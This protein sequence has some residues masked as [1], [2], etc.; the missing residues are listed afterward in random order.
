MLIHFTPS[1]RRWA[2]YL[3]V[4]ALLVLG[5]M[6]KP[7]LVTVPFLLLL[8]D[9]WP[10]GRFRNGAGTASTSRIGLL[11]ARLPVGWRLLAEKTPLMALAAVSCGIARLDA[12]LVSIGKHRS[13]N[14][15]FATRLAN[16]LI[17]YAAYLGQSFYPVDLAPFYPHLGSR[18]PL[19]WAAAHC[20]YWW[21]SAR[22]PPTVGAAGPICPW[23]GSG[24]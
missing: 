2:R 1:G 14:Y 6:A 8:L 4:A 7:M 5:L 19:A 3:A 13:I 9:Y 23:V 11:F 15:R 16:A 10:L 24:F 18:L 17:A 21:R 20:F 12:L 22:S